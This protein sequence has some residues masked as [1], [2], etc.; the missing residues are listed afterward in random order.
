MSSITCVEFQTPLNR[1]LT[2]QNKV[3]KT[4]CVT[5]LYSVQGSMGTRV[6]FQYFTAPVK[7][8]VHR[9]NRLTVWKIVR[10]V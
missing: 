5:S 2:K 7:C 10:T 6:Y 3:N 8:C 4:F 1:G 9:V